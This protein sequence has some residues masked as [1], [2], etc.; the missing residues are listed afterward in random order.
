M[1]SLLLGMLVT[2]LAVPVLAQ[3]ESLGA[4]S[5]ALSA[6][7]GAMRANVVGGLRGI[8]RNPY[9]LPLPAVKVTVRGADASAEHVAVSGEDGAFAF[10]SLTPG[11]YQVTADK[12][13]FAASQ[14]APV[15]LAAAQ[16]FNLDLT[17]GVMPSGTCPACKGGFFHRF[18]K[19]YRDDW[20]GNLPDGP[21]PPYRGY[22]AP[23]SNPPWPFTVWPYGGSPVIGQ[24]DTNVPPLMQTFYGGSHGKWWENSR[25]KIYGWMNVGMNL[26]TSTDKRYGNAPAAYLQIPNSIQLDQTTLYVER[27][28]DTV[29]ADH[30]DWGFR[31]TNLYGMDYRFTTSKGILSNQLIQ[32]KPDGTVGNRYGYDPVMFY[33]DLYWGQVLEGLN[34]RVGRYIS[35]PDIEAQLAPNNY[36]YSHSLLYT[37]DCYTQTGVNA[38]LKIS[39]GWMVQAGLS[40]GCDAA[41]WVGAP[42]AKPT[43]NAC[44]SYT[45]SNGGDNIYLCDNSINSGKYA[46]NNLQA[47]YAT[48][49][50]K[51]NKTW[52]TATESWYQY[53][54]DTPSIFGPI[55]AEVNANGAWCN[56]GQDRCYAPEFA[57]LNYVEKEFN[58]KNY[59]SI[60]NEY[61]NDIKG[62]R[63]GYKTRYTEHQLA[64]GHWVGTSILLRP[65]VSYQYAY[66]YPAFN[67]GT[68][69]G[70]LMFAGDLIFFY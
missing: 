18:I 52:H 68:K 36:T 7:D 65:E 30:F 67:L 6:N 28:P 25:I 22:P 27:V 42:D 21:A 57:I 13:G 33:A 56:P 46:Y 39:K 14:A 4:A 35:L 34:I 26:S 48:W 3:E 38:T 60:R 10:N 66:D 24:P 63:T 11:H 41:F 32:V 69:K 59:L 47:Y 31:F 23:V 29:Q 37:Y 70:Q 1:R 44:V 62:Q 40:A 9:G 49:Y 19:A 17:L 61:F 15:E 55:P 12:D 45:W 64:W 53:Q 20:W 8:T 58:K 54:K 16:F 2:G 43:V 5:E 51:I 50:H